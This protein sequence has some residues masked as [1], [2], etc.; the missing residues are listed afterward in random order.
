MTKIRKID[1]FLLILFLCSL[2]YNFYLINIPI[3]TYDEGIILAGAERVL[4]GQLPY[5]DFWSMY[6]P[7]QFYSLALLFKIFGKSILVERI[8]DLLI[9]SLLSTCI[10][11]IIKKVGLPIAA[12]VTGWGMSLIILGSFNFSGYP[13]YVAILLI[14]LGAHFFLHYVDIRRPHYLIYSGLFITASALFRHDLGAL[15]ALGFI[16]TL[17]VKRFTEKD[18]GFGP[19]CCFTMG[20]LSAGLPIAAWFILEIGLHPVTDQLILTPSVIMPTYR[21]LPYPKPF[22]FNSLQFYVYPL[23]LFGGFFISLLLIIKARIRNS[24][25]FGMLLWSLVGIFFLHQVRVRSDAIHL[26]PAA[27]ASFVVGM[28]LFNAMFI[29]NSKKFK[30]QITRIG[31]YGLLVFLLVPLLPACKNKIKSFKRDYLTTYN[32][33]CRL[34]HDKNDKKIKELIEF[35]KKNT[36][37]NDHI[38]VGV[39][40]HDRFVVNDVAIY[41]LADREYATRY[42]E[43]HPGVT[44]TQSVQKEIIEEL[45][46][47]PVKLIV[48]VPRH[49]KEPNGTA[50]DTK[51]DFLDD[52]IRENYEMTEK[53][54]LYQVWVL[55]SQGFS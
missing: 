10:Y 53:F 54:G 40:N 23:T 6:P 14:F 45:K 11:L 20:L 49:W 21:W 12:A 9:R 26:L 33:F 37:E 38:Y 36:E 4:K 48:L 1:V 32:D 2:I 31:A 27:L 44:N 8:Y 42:H 34:E 5:V 39:E 24:L 16:L 19:L 22:S 51:T 52:Y 50:V 55:K 46:N 18:V 28:M 29:L 43:L 17:L 47:K 3:N 35:V 30:L 15:A 25:S 13:V 7:G 41:F